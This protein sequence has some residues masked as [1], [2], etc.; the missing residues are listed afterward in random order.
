M[1]NG[2][3]SCSCRVSPAQAPTFPRRLNEL[4][5][6]RANSG[7]A[8]VQGRASGPDGERAAY[9]F[10]MREEG[11]GAVVKTNYAVSCVESGAV[12]GFTYLGWYGWMDPSTS[13]SD[14]CVLFLGSMALKRMGRK[15]AASF[16]EADDDDELPAAY[17]RRRRLLIK[18]VQVGLPPFFVTLLCLGR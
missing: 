18:C 7:A 17:V 11:P 10:G 4:V 2:D 15:S 13:Q 14:W 12:C 8:T 16:G 6:F 1:G 5:L 9:V 3:L